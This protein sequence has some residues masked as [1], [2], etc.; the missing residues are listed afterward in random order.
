MAKELRN[1]FIR[2]FD[3]ISTQKS[4]AIQDTGTVILEGARKQGGTD[5]TNQS[6]QTS[7]QANVVRISSRPSGEESNPQS[8]AD[9]QTQTS[10]TLCFAGGRSDKTSLKTQFKQL[11]KREA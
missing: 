9:K 7:Y 6:G 8:K 4:Q 3:K 10:V 5:V 2:K 11:M 1:I